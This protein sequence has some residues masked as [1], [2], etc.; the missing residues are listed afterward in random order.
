[1]AIIRN[2]NNFEINNPKLKELA[3]YC[4]S[5][6]KISI[7][8]AILHSHDPQ[9]FPIAEQDSTEKIFLDYFI[10]LG[11]S[12][13]KRSVERV[14]E[15]VSSN[16]DKRKKELGVLA[17]VDLKSQEP[18]FSLVDTLIANE[19]L[20][21]TD[22]DFE[23]IQAFNT[24]LGTTDLLQE[25]SY[26]PVK[27]SK[28]QFR[29]HEIYCI[30]ET[31]PEWTSDDEI[32]LGGIATDVYGKSKKIRIVEKEGFYDGKKEPFPAEV[33]AE[34]DLKNSAWPKEQAVTLVLAE[35][36]WGGFPSWLDGF[37]N[38]T[39]DKIE[40]AVKKAV[41]AKAGPIV[42]IVVG[43]VVKWTL[44]NLI[45][46][47]KEVV[48][49]DVFPP[50]IVSTRLLTADDTFINNRFTSHKESKDFR[51]H[52]GHYR[53][54]YDW[55]LEWG[56]WELIGGQAKELYAGGND[57]FAIS[58]ATS[59]V[60]QFESVTRTWIEIG[61]PGSQFAVTN[62]E[63]FGLSPDR[64][65]VLRYTGNPKQWERIGEAATSIFAG[66]DIL[67][68]IHPSTGDIYQ[69]EDQRTGWKRI[70][71]PGRMFAANSQKIYGLSL[72][73][74]AIYELDDNNNKWIKIGGAAI[75]IYAGANELIATSPANGHVYRYRGR[76]GEWTAI[77]TEGEQFVITEEGIYGL[78][79]R[80]KVVYRFTGVSNKWQRIGGSYYSLSGGKRRLYALSMQ[81]KDVWM[82][83]G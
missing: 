13:R 47:M 56:N 61:G 50:A 52:G 11:E 40:S 49:D 45:G 35:I 70:G 74:S 60:Y 69:Y 25:A 68:S 6:T 5:T 51:G 34:F 15:R 44:G 9:N 14:L 43:K 58:P 2:V 67:Y 24:P 65:A 81:S 29:L 71:G 16:P 30:D 21:L 10:S 75:R 33:L 22:K 79:P 63:F 46:W 36:D 42:G 3:N 48:E 66:G 82:L 76:P 32:K 54:T 53:I 8:K 18:V 1:M 27:P 31:N 83:T 7:E 19:N 57:L 73:R 17:K 78:S 55:N 64:S 80:E 26:E 28:L 41:S 77:G 4:L 38:K 37:F 12:Q 23:I 20:R 59:N 39:A 72:D 62:N